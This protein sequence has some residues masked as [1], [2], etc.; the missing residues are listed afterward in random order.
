MNIR[1]R[2]KLIPLQREEMYL[3]NYREPVRVALLV[4]EHHICRPRI[5]KILA[6]GHK[7]IRR[8]TP[9]HVFRNRS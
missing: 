3:K 5:H 1:K 7:R 4:E 2:T 8:L 9:P 6:R